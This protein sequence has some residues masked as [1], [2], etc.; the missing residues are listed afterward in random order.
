MIMKNNLIIVAIII[1]IIAGAAGFFGGIKYQQSKTPSF[2]RNFQG[3]RGQPNGNNA[4]QGLRPVSGTIISQDE[5][6]ITVKLADESS[7]IILLTDNSTINKTEEGSKEDL[8]E[9]TEVTVFGQANSDGSITAQNIQ[10]G[11]G[12]FGRQE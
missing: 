11:T 10:I 5:T 1:A 3:Q 4:N 9:G 7:K 2:S 8:T 6:S 12:F